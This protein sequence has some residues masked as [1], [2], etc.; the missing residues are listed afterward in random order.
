[1]TMRPDIGPRLDSD[2]EPLDRV[3]EIGM[4]IVM[5]PLTGRRDRTGRKFV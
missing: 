5:G 2:A 1:M 4:E 3:C